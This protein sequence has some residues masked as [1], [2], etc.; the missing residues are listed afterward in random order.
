NRSAPPETQPRARGG[1]TTAQ[2]GAAG[3]GNRVGARR[4][5]HPVQLQRQVTGST[6]ELGGELRP[7]TITSRRSSGG[8]ALK[9]T[10]TAPAGACRPARHYG[11]ARTGRGVDRA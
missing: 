9:V 5:A 2:G 6:C 1:L 10:S 4:Q 7:G 11:V 3:C 8:G